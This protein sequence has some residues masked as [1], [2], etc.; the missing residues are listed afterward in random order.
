MWDLIKCSREI[1][2]VF[3]RIYYSLQRENTGN[4][5]N[6]ARKNGQFFVPIIVSV[7]LW[8]TGTSLCDLL[9]NSS[10]RAIQL[11]EYLMLIL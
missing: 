5:K 7:F 3:T 8:N 11:A 10:A 9:D 4:W 1:I 2:E 6:I